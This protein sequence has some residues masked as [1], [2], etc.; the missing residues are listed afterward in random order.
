MTD[1]TNPNS[2]TVERVVTVG[3]LRR[4]IS[5]MPDEAPVLIE[6]DDDEFGIMTHKAF[7][8]EAK[9]AL[10]SELSLMNFDISYFDNYAEGSEPVLILS[11]D[12]EPK[13]LSLEHTGPGQTISRPMDRAIAAMQP[14]GIPVYSTSLAKEGIKGLA[15]KP[16]ATGVFDADRDAAR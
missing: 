16:D 13:N 8:A 12:T 1:L 5:S 14:E 10:S 3:D 2:A 15:T 9:R 11:H 6:I 7:F 4:L